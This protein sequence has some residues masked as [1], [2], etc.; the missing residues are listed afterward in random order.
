[1]VREDVDAL[2]E[3]R[4]LVKTYRSANHQ[5]EALRGVSLDVK[6]TDVFGV[7]GLSGAGKSTLVRCINLLERPD[8]GQVLID[9]IDITRQTERQ[10]E[11]TRQKIGMIFQHFNLMRSKTVRD[12]IA[13]P[14]RYLGKSKQETRSRVNELLALVGLE[15]KGAS[16]PSQLSGGQKQRVAIARA[17]ANNPKILL[18]DE[19]TS[20]LD[21]QTTESIL[22]LLKK[23][24]R[25]LGLT[26]VVITHAMSVVKDICNKIAVMENGEVVENGSTYDVFSNPHS[27]TSKRFVSAL[28]SIDKVQQNVSGLWQTGALST[29][30]IYHL[31]FCGP[32][33]FNSYI[34]QAV[35]RFGVDIG[36]VY[37]SIEFIQDRPLG[38][39]F[40]S[41][42]GEPNNVVNLLAWFGQEG[43]LVDTI[44]RDSHL[45]P[46]VGKEEGIA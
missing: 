37:G 3:L 31:R 14:L 46:I 44:S 6:H 26:I 15:D 34:S 40:V 10:L 25:E 23:L 27:E 39:L 8:S 35:T 16:Y 18:S 22:Q 33:A 38:S 13:L 5:V 20:A 32:T 43:I 1:M 36:I 7:I 45:T 4:D 42:R 24:N 29:E 21:P 30:K 9:G 19:A 11:Q 2:I 12:N 41:V 28:F 17:L